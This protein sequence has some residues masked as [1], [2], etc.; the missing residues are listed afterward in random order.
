MFYSIDMRKRKKFIFLLVLILA[1]GILAAGINYVFPVKYYDIIEEYSEQYGL[2]TQLVCAMIR[3]E[4]GFD[5]TAKSHKNATGLMQII[6]QTADWAAEEIGIEN[7]DYSRITEPD[8]NI[9]IGCWYVSRLINQYGGNVDTAL[10]AYNAGSGNVSKWLEQETEKEG[11][12]LSSIPF[13]ETRGYVE[14]VH[15]YEKIYTILLKFHGK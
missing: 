9:Q 13:P 4:S 14:K 6:Q 5:H 1:A 7:Y 12:H 2:S 8:M 15:L 11:Y 3:T 10:A